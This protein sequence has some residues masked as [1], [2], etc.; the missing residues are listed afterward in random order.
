MRRADRW[1]GSIEG[2]VE[3]ETWTQKNNDQRAAAK[4][5]VDCDATWVKAGQESDE[6][7]QPFPWT[8]PPTGP[9]KDLLCSNW[10]YPSLQSSGSFL[11]RLCLHFF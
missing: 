9:D 4:T 2:R 3:G 1:E 5:K 8:G 7:M 11:A 6:K 10:P